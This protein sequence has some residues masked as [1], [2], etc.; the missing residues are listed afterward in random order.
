MQ[1]CENKFEFRGSDFLFL[2]DKGSDFIFL[3]A[4]EERIVFL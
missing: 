1:E 3:S 2:K 4:N